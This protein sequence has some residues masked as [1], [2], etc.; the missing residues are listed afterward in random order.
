[1]ELTITNLTIALLMLWI[2]TG[3]YLNERL[4]LVQQKLE[5]ILDQFDGLR[6][7]LYEIDPQFDEERRLTRGLYESVSGVRPS[8]DG[9]LL[10]DLEREK[11]EKGERTLSTGFRSDSRF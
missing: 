1:M 2:A 9:M 4:N 10:N 8:F 11:R 3:W 5:V 7:Y 6:E